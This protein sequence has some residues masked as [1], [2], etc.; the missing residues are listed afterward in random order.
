MGVKTAA[1]RSVGR[2]LLLLLVLLQHWALHWAGKR[3][4]TPCSSSCLAAG[5]MEQGQVVLL[6]YGNNSLINL[7]WGH[8]SETK[9]Q[10]S[11]QLVMNMFVETTP[12]KVE[13]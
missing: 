1:P 3:S 13:R 4:L 12:S 11:Q 2:F 7:C 8:S 10:W 9:A 6:L 5:V